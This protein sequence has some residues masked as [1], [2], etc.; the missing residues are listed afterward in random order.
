M[1]HKNKVYNTVKTK[2]LMKKVLVTKSP[3][4][5]RYYFMK[6]KTDIKNIK[7]Q[8][9]VQSDNINSFSVDHVLLTCSKHVRNL[10]REC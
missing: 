2:E 3:L 10:T 4:S 8:Q 9:G 6:I 7:N 1:K 5:L